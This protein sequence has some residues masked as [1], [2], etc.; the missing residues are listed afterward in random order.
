MRFHCDGGDY[1]TDQMTAFATKNRG[2]PFI[3]ISPDFAHVFVQIMERERGVTIRHASAEEIR[4]LAN[5]YRLPDLLRALPAAGPDQ[6]LTGE[7]P[8]D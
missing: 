6:R 7:N 4:R 2:M 3:Y 1:D 8:T 5:T